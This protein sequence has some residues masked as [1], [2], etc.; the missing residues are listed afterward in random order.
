MESVWS[1]AATVRFRTVI[2]QEWTEDPVT[3]C[4]QAESELARDLRYQP[5]KG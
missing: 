4:L 2:A 3:S 5:V 1:S